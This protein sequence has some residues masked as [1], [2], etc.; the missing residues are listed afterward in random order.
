MWSEHQPITLHCLGACE[1]ATF[2]PSPPLLSASPSTATAIESRSL[3]V[4]TNFPQ[5]WTASFFPHHTC[6]RSSHCCWAVGPLGTI[7]HTYHLQVQRGN[8]LWGAFWPVRHEKGRQCSSF[9][10]QVNSSESYSRRFFRVPKSKHLVI[11]CSAPLSMTSRSPVL[12]SFSL[13]PHP[14]ISTLVVGCTLGG[15]RKKKVVSECSLLHVWITWR[16]R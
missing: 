13:G 16:T 8:A 10:A 7:S 6:F 1:W 4:A 14:C 12:P 5:E 11:L 15:N 2:C 3:Q 9:I